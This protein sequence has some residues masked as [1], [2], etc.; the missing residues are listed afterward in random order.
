MLQFQMLNRKGRSNQGSRNVKCQK[1]RRK[2]RPTGRSRPLDQNHDGFTRR[3]LDARI[4]I[5]N[6][7]RRRVIG[8]P[9][10]SQSLAR[11]CPAL[12]SP[13]NIARVHGSRSQTTRH[14][15]HRHLGGARWHLHGKRLGRPTP[16]RRVRPIVI[17]EID[18][19]DARKFPRLV[20]G[21]C[22]KEV[23]VKVD[24]ESLHGVAG[25]YKVGDEK[26]GVLVCVHSSGVIIEGDGFP[27]G[28]LEAK[29]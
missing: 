5:R 28:E 15:H 13:R 22:G 19:R 9:R 23:R 8:A 27:L 2:R 14:P 21:V 26:R 12:T 1:E 11:H 3:H 29:A 25:G 7:D 24:F 6:L 4:T 18:Q 20:G 17:V 10:H 16:R